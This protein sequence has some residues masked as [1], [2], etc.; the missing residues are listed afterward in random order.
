M[1]RNKANVVAGS[2]KTKLLNSW[3]RKYIF[4]MEFYPE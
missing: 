3:P 2:G 1:G 4:R